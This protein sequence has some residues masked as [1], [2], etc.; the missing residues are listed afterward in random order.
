MAW[1]S[2]VDQGWDIGLAPG[3]LDVDEA[4]AA[5]IGQ[6][7][8]SYAPERL[9]ALSNYLHVVAQPYS[10]SQLSAT[11]DAADVAL[12][13]AGFHNSAG[14]GLCTL[15]DAIRVEVTILSDAPLTPEQTAQVEAVLAPFGDQVRYK[16]SPFPRTADAIVPMTPPLPSR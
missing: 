2:N 5:I 12:R 1:I 11:R 16:V 9:A 15:S 10:E 3:P 13:T 14:I 4:R 7:A 6:L 8:A